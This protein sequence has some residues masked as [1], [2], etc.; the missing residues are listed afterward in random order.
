ERPAEP[1]VLP[2][3]LERERRAEREPEHVRTLESKGLDET[4]QASGVVGHAE[5]FGWVRR[6]AASRRVPGHYLE[7][8]RQVLDL[9][10]P[11]TAVAEEAVK[12]DQWRPR[13]NSLVGDSESVY[14]HHLPLAVPFS[15]G[16]DRPG[17]TEGSRCPTGRRST[18]S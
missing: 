10:S 9:A 4:S 11:D 7:L 1:G 13:A 17:S 18:P 2:V 8:V 6:S 16:S 5:G 15:R 3:E 14:D 12:K